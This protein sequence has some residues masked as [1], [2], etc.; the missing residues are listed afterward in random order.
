M[1]HVYEPV[2]IY[3]RA[4]ENESGIYFSTREKKPDRAKIKALAE[5][6]DD[7]P[8]ETVAGLRRSYTQ[9]A[10][11]GEVVEPTYELA[12]TITKRYEAIYPLARESMEARVQAAL[13]LLNQEPPPLTEDDHNGKVKY[14]DALDKHLHLTRQSVDTSW[15]NLRGWCDELNNKNQ[16]TGDRMVSNRVLSALDKKVAQAKAAN[17]AKQNPKTAAAE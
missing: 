9:T 13:A 10:Q 7:L 15:R 2:S 1:A 6:Q 4:K 17:D 3:R 11:D 5:L 8:P 16:K 12:Q 14:D